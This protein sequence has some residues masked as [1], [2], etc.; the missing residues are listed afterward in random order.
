MDRRQKKTRVSIF[1]A[2]CELLSKKHYNQITVGEIIERADIGRATFYAHFETKDY[3][4]KELCEELF[5]HIFDCTEQGNEKHNHIFSCNAPNS[6]FLHLI[7][8]L[9]NNDNNILALLYC[10]N[11]DLFLGY[12][13]SNLKELI[14]R[15]LHL[16]PNK[17]TNVP[18]EFWI[19]HISS[20]FVETVKWWI[21]NGMK[22]TP[23]DLS[24]YFYAVLYGEDNE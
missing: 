9:Q 11:N 21:D 18:I 16:F 23:Y 6:V 8:H 15:Q 2:F 10:D 22:E 3:L 19:N 14:K 12:F 5:C 20:T 4:L 24:N 7:Q 17:T 13:K 1:T